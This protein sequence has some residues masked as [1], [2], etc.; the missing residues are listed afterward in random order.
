MKNN[1]NPISRAVDLWVDSIL[2]GYITKFV[3]NTIMSYG[4]AKR[5]FFPRTTR[6][7]LGIFKNLDKYAYT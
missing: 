3:V 1:I 5:N 6:K 7:I 2:E 4:E